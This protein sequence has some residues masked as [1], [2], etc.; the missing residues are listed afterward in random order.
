RSSVLPSPRAPL[1]RTSHHGR[2]STNDTS[3][4]KTLLPLS[5]GTVAPLVPIVAEHPVEP[6]ERS[7]HA[8]CEQI[9]PFVVS[10]FA[11]WCTEHAGDVGNMTLN[12]PDIGIDEPNA[13]T[14]SGLP[15]IERAGS[16]IGGTPACWANAPDATSAATR[17]A[18][19][20]RIIEY[21]LLT[22]GYAPDCRRA[23]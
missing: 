19:I 15:K 20:L 5:S 8:G 1:P 4:E 21:R 14:G 10:P 17:A 16:G 3:P 11:H 23:R 18:Q 22:S 12:N 13:V 7:E 9:R 2:P 6:L